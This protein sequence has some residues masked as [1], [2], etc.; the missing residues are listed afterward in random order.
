M[1]TQS[2]GRNLEEFNLEIE[3]FCKRNCKEKRDKDRKIMVEDQGVQQTRNR[4]LQEYTM[5][6]PGDNLS[7]IVRPNVDANNF[8]IKPAIIQMISQFQFG[9]LST[10]DP[11]AHLAQFLEIC[12]TFKMNGV[13][14]DA[15]KLRLFPFSLRDKAKLWLHS[16][17][18]Q[19]IRSW[20]VLSRAFLSKY[21]PPGKTAK[22][23][24]EITSFAKHSGE[25]LYEA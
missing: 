14:S 15:I 24:Q 19:S 12:D 6:N 23:R 5:P 17:T 4:A 2:K 9:G 18:P 16:L 3:K 25:S 22:F 21:F 7:S 13:S 10:E 8:E 11:N 1:N 20:D